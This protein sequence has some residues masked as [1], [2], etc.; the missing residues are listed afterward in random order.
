MIEKTKDLAKSA[1]ITTI[2]AKKIYC[3]IKSVFIYRNKK[4][5][6]Y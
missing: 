5:S 3:L 2:S 6:I 1:K 4:P